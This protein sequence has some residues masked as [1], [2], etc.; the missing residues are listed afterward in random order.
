MKN[1][2][3]LMKFDTLLQI[4][5]PMTVTDQKFLEFKMAAA[6]ILKIAFLAITH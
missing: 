2:A 5:N 3:I 6:A 1:R 4:L